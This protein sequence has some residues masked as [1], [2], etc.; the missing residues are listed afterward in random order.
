MAQLCGILRVAPI[1][2]VHF[3]ASLSG[4]GADTRFTT[5]FEPDFPPAH[6]AAS[7]FGVYKDGQMSP[8]VW[9][10]LGPRLA[11]TFGG[12]TC[13]VA[14]GGAIAPSSEALSSAI[15]DYARANGPTDELLTRIA[16]A[17]QG[18]LI[19][20]LTV[21]GR[22]PV[23]GKYTVKDD[24]PAHSGS[25]NY[26]APSSLTGNGGMGMSRGFKDTTAPPGDRDTSV[27][28]MSA[29][30]YSV[31][32]QKSVALVDMEYSGDSVDEAVKKFAERLA[33]ALPGTTCGGWSWK[34]KVDA[35]QI[36]KLGGS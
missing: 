11:A 4:C 23:P 21:A 16:P 1:L 20:V 8:D 26:N 22:L 3:V 24:T 14:F 15:A 6:H 13:E 28:E 18:D 5:R 25:R 34:D 2:A 12:R 17:A 31:S 7:V 36:R 30:V 32:Q 9:G 27:L 35:D 29:R 19:V 10:D 33:Q